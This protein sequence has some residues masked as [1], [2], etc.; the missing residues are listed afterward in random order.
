MILFGNV[1]PMKDID[2][3]GQKGEK[4]KTKQ[5]DINGQNIDEGLSI[6]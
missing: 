5:K 1:F 3:N 2:L 6:K 4:S